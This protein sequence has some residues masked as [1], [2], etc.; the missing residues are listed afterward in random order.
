[1]KK[2]LIN[3]LPKS[4]TNLLEKFAIISGYK[5]SRV[6]FSS[7]NIYGNYSNIKKILRG[8]LVLGDHTR[9]GLDTNACVRDRWLVKQL[10]KIK[11][12]EYGT[13]HMPYTTKLDYLL[14]DLSVIQIVRDPRAVIVSWAKYVSNM[15]W[16]YLYNSLHR[17]PLT[18]QI[19]IIIDG[20]EY[21]G[22][23]VEGFNNVLLDV[24]GWKN[25]NNACLVRYEDLVGPQGGGSDDDQRYMI[26][27]LID[28]IDVDVDVDCVADSIY[29]GTKTFRQ[30]KINAWMSELD[31]KLVVRLTEEFELF[32][33]E[34]GYV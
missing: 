34:M 14:R 17:K 15:K 21:G 13:G 4:G 9:V 3:S 19:T 2:L 30:G 32:C 23:Y 10:S 16:H 31:D 12:G 33:R 26:S 7:T 29:G 24:L 5:E 6:N 11:L 1:M 27:E 25:S 22:V 28:F 20:G 8:P 18:E